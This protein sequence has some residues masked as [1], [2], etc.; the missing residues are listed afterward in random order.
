MLSLL[1]PSPRL[2]REYTVDAVSEDSVGAHEER[3]TVHG[4]WIPPEPSVG[5]FRWGFAISS[6][7]N[8]DGVEVRHL[9]EDGDWL[10]RVQQQ[11]ADEEDNPYGEN[12]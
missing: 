10:A 7:T 8:G 11:I 5:V 3:V 9:I 6:V 2:V 4:E 12:Y 1:K